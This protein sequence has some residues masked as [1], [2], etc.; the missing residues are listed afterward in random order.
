MI[1]NVLV[2]EPFSIITRMQLGQKLG[3]PMG[4]LEAIELEASKKSIPRKAALMMILNYWFENVKVASLAKLSEALSS[5]PLNMRTASDRIEMLIMDTPVEIFDVE[6]I[7]K[8]LNSF[9]WILGRL[10]KRLEPRL[11]QQDIAI[12]QS[13]GC[14]WAL[15]KWIESNTKY[16]TWNKL[17]DAIAE[18]D[19]D[20]SM[21]V[22]ELIPCKKSMN[23][24]EVS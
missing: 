10:W 19:M 9:V 2:E 7:A 21:K 18:E 14:E 17:V 16:A 3:I 1:V 24:H 12:V 20:A 23:I 6:R 4:K 13:L 15:R 8:V 5:D 11:E 22:K